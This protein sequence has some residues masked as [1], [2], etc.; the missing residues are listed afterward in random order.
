MPADFETRVRQHIERLQN[1]PPGV[2]EREVA[3]KRLA[4]FR[5]RPGR[6]APGA[7]PTPRQAYEMLFFEYMGL[8]AAELPVVYETETEIAWRSLNPCPT[9]AACQA[10]GLDTRRVCRGAYEKSTQ[11]LVSQLD[12]QL[13]FLRSYTEIRPYAP[14]CLERIVRLDFSAM[15]AQA[16]S[17][18][19]GALV[20]LGSRVIASSA[21]PHPA[22]AAI[23]Q[24][25][26]LIGDPDLGGMVL[27]AASEPCPACAALAARANLSAVVYGQGREEPAAPGLAQVLAR[28]EVMVETFGWA[29]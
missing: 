12:P 14:H 23:R 28:S 6:T 22:A 27:F 19:E 7:P 21:G 24:A 8:P 2:I 10:L 5:Q 1:S 3:H 17:A 15:L 29:G 26:A 9:L 25:A 11:A 13:R 4:W 20:A 16:R 18:G